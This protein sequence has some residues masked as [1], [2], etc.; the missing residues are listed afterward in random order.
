MSCLS[1]RSAFSA[2]WR[3]CRRLRKLPCERFCL[4]CQVRLFLRVGATLAA[5][6]FL[7][8][9]CILA[10]A[11]RASCSL[12]LLR[13]VVMPSLCHIFCLHCI[14]LSAVCS[15]MVLA[16]QTQSCYRALPQPFS[17][18]LYAFISGPSVCPHNASAKGGGARLRVGTASSA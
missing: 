8:L 10:Q 3:I 5:F 7:A 15:D 18:Q 16:L 14:V 4:L 1:G 11:R 9:A 17:L 13:T 6:R 12:R 2:A